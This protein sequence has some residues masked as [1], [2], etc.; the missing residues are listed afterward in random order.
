MG[1][2]TLRLKPP[3]DVSTISHCQGRSRS[4]P[5]RKDAKPFIEPVDI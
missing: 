3:D 1:V 2:R 4:G 5:V